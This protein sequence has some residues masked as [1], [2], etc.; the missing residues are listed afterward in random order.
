MQIEPL[1]LQARFGGLFRVCT[2]ESRIDRT[3]KNFDFIP[4]LCAGVAL[5]LGDMLRAAYQYF[6]RLSS[7]FCVY[8][9]FFTSSLCGGSPEAGSVYAV[10][11]IYC[12]FFKQLPIF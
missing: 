10:N 7:L 6:L 11:P 8:Q 5:S 12:L 9:V 2:Q 3:E 4:V 1:P